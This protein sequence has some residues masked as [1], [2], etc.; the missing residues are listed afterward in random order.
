MHG[1]DPETDARPPKSAASGARLA[2]AKAKPEPVMRAA[3]NSD[4]MVINRS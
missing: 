4:A 1:G 3:R 2:V